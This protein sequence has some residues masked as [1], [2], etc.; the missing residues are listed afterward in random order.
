ME[1]KYTKRIYIIEELRLKGKYAT[2]KMDRLD[3]L[4]NLIIQ[5]L[6]ME[7]KSFIMRMEI[8]SLKKKKK[9]F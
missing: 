6:K 5:G 4:P 1:K 9:G 8:I 3:I 7:S 2:T